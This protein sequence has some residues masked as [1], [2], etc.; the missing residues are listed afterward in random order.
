MSRKQFFIILTIIVAPVLIGLF[1]SIS[2]HAG[3]GSLLSRPSVKKI[4]LVRVMDVIYESEDY[5][6]QLKSLREDNTIAGVLVRVDSPGG[7][8]APSQEIYHEI[9]LYQAAK[10]PLIVSMGNLAASGGYYI[11]SPAQRIFANPGTI[12]GSIGVI[13]QHSEYFKL[14]DKIGVRI[15]TMKAGA[16]KDVMSPYR[17]MT[18]ADTKLIQ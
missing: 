17:E 3:P 6:R 13:F 9:L 10:K 15:N 7:A 18:H 1:I 12:T 2:E 8:V 5:V 14:L 11:A 16:Y 4:G